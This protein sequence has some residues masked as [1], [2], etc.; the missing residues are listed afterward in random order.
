MVADRSERHDGARHRM[1]A[2]EPIDR[3]YKGNDE[4]PFWALEIARVLF[5]DW[6]ETGVRVRDDGKGTVSV[7]SPDSQR[8]WCRVGAS[9]DEGPLMRVESIGDGTMLVRFSADGEAPAHPP[10][11]HPWPR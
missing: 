5:P 2:A 9:G 7:T 11:P 10:L 4:P 3:I 1:T 8:A 6:R